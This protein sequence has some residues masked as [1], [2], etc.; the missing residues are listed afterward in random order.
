MKLKSFLIIAFF[1]VFHFSFAQHT[2]IINSNRPSESMSAFAVGK[3]VIQL[4]SGFSFLNENHKLLDY[5][6]KGY[7]LDLA[8]RYGFFK[9]QLEFIS[10]IGYQNDKFTT[11][12][13]QQK[14]SGLKTTTLGFKY[15]VYDP[16]RNR[17]ETINIYSWK[18]N[19]KFKWNQFIPAL[20]VY[21]GANLNFSNVY[22]AEPDNISMISPKVMLITQ[23]IF[24]NGYVF[25][26]NIYMDK[27]STPR[28]SLNYLVTI[29][30]AINDKWSVFFENKGIKGDYYADGIFSGGAAYLLTDELQIDASL[31]KNYKDTPS[32]FYGGFGISWRSDTNYKDVLIRSGKEDKKDK[33][34]KG[35]DKEKNKK[36]LDEVEVEK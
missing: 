1:T 8:V 24:G 6:T 20:S 7:I 12:Y 5:K 15:L 35:K 19:H 4:E 27:I 30:K 3:K 28:V 36:R 22:N 25:I 29:T 16:F 33:S 13:D 11:P 31:S 14:R 32:I 34:K 10:E 26:T 18:A 9:E 2:D 21:G 17:K 23:N